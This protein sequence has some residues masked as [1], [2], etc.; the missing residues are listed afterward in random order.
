MNAPQ[1]ITFTISS[2]TESYTRD[3]CRYRLLFGQTQGDT[4]MHE[5]YKSNN[6]LTKH[7]TLTL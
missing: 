1:T 2:F 5:M 4:D 3:G 6:H 7:L